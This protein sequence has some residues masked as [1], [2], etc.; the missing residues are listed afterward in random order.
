MV[1]ALVF[2][3]KSKTSITISLWTVL[4]LP[5][6]SQSWWLTVEEIP[7]QPKQA[8]VCCVRAPAVNVSA[9]LM[10]CTSTEITVGQHAVMAEGE[11]PSDLDSSHTSGAAGPPAINHL[12]PGSNSHH[13]LLTLNHPV[14][15]L[16]NGEADFLI[17]IFLNGDPWL[18]NISGDHRSN[19]ANPSHLLLR[20][21]FPHRKSYV[22]RCVTQTW[23]A[24]DIADSDGCF[25]TKH[26]RM[27]VKHWELQHCCFEVFSVWIIQ[28]IYSFKN[29]CCWVNV[30]RPFPT[31]FFFTVPTHWTM[32]YFKNTA[33]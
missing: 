2:W 4:H 6:I 30:S 7:L 20:A 9:P 14:T 10:E 16:E 29:I 5:L 27:P 13:L 19:V 3:I 24:Q 22:H 31:S 18:P 32:N 8:N 12:R 1:H 11:R 15:C 25:L 21:A 17:I 23:T 26:T 33:R 28:I